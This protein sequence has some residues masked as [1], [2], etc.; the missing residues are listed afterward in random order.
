MREIGRHITELYLGD[1]R[2]RQQPVTH[3]FANL[4]QA[5]DIDITIQPDLHDIALPGPQAN[6]RFLGVDREG[7]DLC[8]RLIDIL[9]DTHA[10]DAGDQLQIDRSRSLARRRRDFLDALNAADGFLDR[11]QDA[12][13]DLFGAAPG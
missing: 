4:S 7:A 13:L 11:Q 10:V 3:A 2:F 12:L 8:D 5:P 9:V 6:L 1:V